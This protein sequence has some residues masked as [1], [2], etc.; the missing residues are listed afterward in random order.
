[1]NYIK[2]LQKENTEMR[3]AILATDRELLEFKRFLMTDKFNGI[4]PIDG[5][6]KDWMSTMDIH[7]KLESLRDTLYS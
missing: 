7:A 1:M 3:D 5:S 6:R 2:Q 4:C